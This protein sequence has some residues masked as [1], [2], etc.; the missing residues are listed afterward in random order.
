MVLFRR[1]GRTKPT[2]TRGLPGCS[3]HQ[4]AFV[5]PIALARQARRT[6]LAFLHP[7]TTLAVVEEVLATTK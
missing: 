5:A 7:E 4:I 3:K 1:T 2:T 6:R